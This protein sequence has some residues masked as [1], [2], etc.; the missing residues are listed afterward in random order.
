M[1]SLDDLKILIPLVAAVIAWFVN[2]WSKR[3]W[4]EYQRKEER[5]NSLLTSLKGFYVGADP[6]TATEQKEEFLRQLVL[7]WMYCP[8]V[9]IEAAYKFLELV[10]VGAQASDEEKERAVGAFVLEVRK[11]LLKSRGWPWGKTKL[12]ATDFRHFR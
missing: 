12:K 7:S 9:V 8:D 10:A 2:E 6:G 4:E 5:Y 11:D 3:K 1:S